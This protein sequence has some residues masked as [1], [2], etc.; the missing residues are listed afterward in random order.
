MFNVRHHQSKIFLIKVSYIICLMCATIKARSFS[1]LFSCF[2]VMTLNLLYISIINN[3]GLFD[4]EYLILLYIY[5]NK[6]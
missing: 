4:I 3:I 6:N 5:G 2:Q 1:I